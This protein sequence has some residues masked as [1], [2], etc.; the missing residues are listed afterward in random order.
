MWCCGCAGFLHTS[1]AR[2][3]EAHKL[4]HSGEYGTAA[5]T[6]SQAL[7]RAPKKDRALYLVETGMLAHFAR[8]HQRSNRLL[9]QAE[10]AIQANYTRSMSQIAASLLVN[11]NMLAYFGEDYENVYINCFKALNYLALG[12]PQSAFV[13][14]R[15]MDEKMEVLGDRHGRWAEVINRQGKVETRISAAPNRFVTSAL[16]RYLGLLL[17]RAEGSFDDAR[18]DLKKMREAWRSQPDIYDFPRPDFAHLLDPLADGLCRVNVLAF[19]GLA[20]RKEARR[21]SVHTH[22]NRVTLVEATRPA[23]EMGIGTVS[24]IRWQGMEPGLSFQ[25]EIPM[26]ERRGSNVARIEVRCAGRSIAPQ[27]IESPQ[28]AA[29]ATFRT[30]LPL[31]YSKAVFRTVTKGLAAE[32][33]KEEMTESGRVNPFL[34]VVVDAAVGVTEQADLRI[35]H[36]LPAKAYAAEMHLPPGT[37]EVAVSFFD[38]HGRLLK[39]SS[40]PIDATRNTINLVEAF[41]LQ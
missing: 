9:E 18:I 28:N 6:M 7:E 40:H 1:G 29:L 22:K 8:E 12:N 10:Q 41:C 30:K 23:G 2:Y 11:D 20:P 35:A 4:L 26:I 31:I 36:F 34:N 38:E 13:E 15:R 14:V 25:F 33:L 37:H 32:R 19:T 27:Q 5:A 17:Y 16:G 39:T 3:E 24:T 21:L